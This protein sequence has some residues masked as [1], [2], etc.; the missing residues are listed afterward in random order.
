MHLWSIPFPSAPFLNLRANFHQIGEQLVIL[1][2][3]HCYGVCEGQAPMQGTV[4]EN[5]NKAHK[6][7]SKLLGHQTFFTGI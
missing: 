1:E 7:G 5:T 4:A 3:Q 2:I 6:S